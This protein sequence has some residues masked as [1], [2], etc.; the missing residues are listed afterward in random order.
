MEWTRLYIR[1]ALSLVFYLIYVMVL[2]FFGNSIGAASLLAA[3]PVAAAATVK[4]WPGVFLSLL[5]IP[6]TL[7][8][9]DRT[10]GTKLQD[11]IWLLLPSL[12]AVVAVGALTGLLVRTL[13]RRKQLEADVETARADGELFREAVAGGIDQTIELF[14]TVSRLVEAGTGQQKSSG[15]GT[16]A[17]I[18]RRIALL[19]LIYRMIYAV[20]RPPAQVELS[21]F[22]PDLAAR[23]MADLG[24]EAAELNGDL[25]LW[26]VAPPSAA[27]IGSAIV[28][29]ATNSVRYGAGVDASV[30]VDLELAHDGERVELRFLDHGAGFPDPVLYGQRNGPPGLGIPIVREI[31][32][33]LGGTLHLVNETGACY[34]LEFPAILT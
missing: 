29:M 5:N 34:V 11:G 2:P 7:I 31:V 6:V 21:R 26:Q 18:D 28:E 20:P 25:D 23:T 8:V 14:R 4:M 13:R 19:P 32:T 22:L 33:R 10:L 15:T 24:A 17:E 12:V 30:V 1:F 3:L 27:L 9:T 16:V